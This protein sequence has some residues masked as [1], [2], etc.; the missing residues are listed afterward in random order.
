MHDRHI[1]RDLE[2]TLV[3]L[4]N[5]IRDRGFT[6]MEVQA[7][8]GWGR[9]FISQLLTRQKSLRLESLLM[10]LKVV[11]VEPLSFFV[12]VYQPGEGIA[13]LDARPSP[14]EL[15]GKLLDLQLR[16]EALVELLKSKR[17]VTDAEL[18]KALKKA[19]LVS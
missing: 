10:I 9:S 14:A 15:P 19:R 1:D 12:E 4:R 8:L 3:H 11:G 16:V 7:A 17:L 6:Q 5:V 18:G 13:A 2:R